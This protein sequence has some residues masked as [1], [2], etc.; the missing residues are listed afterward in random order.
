MKR[1]KDIST[2]PKPVTNKLDHLID[3]VVRIHGGLKDGEP[4]FLGTGMVIAPNWVLTCNHVAMEA[5]PHTGE[6][7]ELPHECFFIQIDVTGKLI[8]ARLHAH[9]RSSDLALLELGD[10]IAVNY[11]TFLWRISGDFTPNICEQHYSVEGFQKKNHG[12]TLEEWRNLTV[13]IP[14]RNKRENYLSEL[15]LAGSTEVGS[16]GSPLILKLGSHTLC[17]GM[18]YLGG[19]KS[20]SSKAASGDIIVRFLNSNH[21]KGVRKIAAE[22]IFIASHTQPAVTPN[23]SA[24]TRYLLISIIGFIFLGFGIWGIWSQ[25]G[26]VSHTNLTAHS[27]PVPQCDSEFQQIANTTDHQGFRIL[28]LSFAGSDIDAMIEGKK[29][30]Q[31]LQ[32]DI[33]T[34]KRSQ[35]EQPIWKTAHLTAEGL[36]TQFLPCTVASHEDARKVGIA[37]QFDLAIWGQVT[38]QIVG[39]H[40]EFSIYPFATATSFNALSR[41]PEKPQKIQQDAQFQL[42]IEHFSTIDI[43]LALYAHEQEQQKVAAFHFKKAY[44]YISSTKD[45]WQ[46]LLIAA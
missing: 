3:Y 9:D 40:R 34:Y 22:D 27:Q 20:D 19:G 4:I 17:I 28:V 23:S 12:Q 26:I 11:P 29:I 5:N 7:S 21:I 2:S 43:M 16:S 18:M 42:P 36:N 44:R 1:R 13:L 41:T 35:E 45:A 24:L 14:Q 32:L 33:E 10:S 39:S 25:K 31:Q 37:Q 46:L 6:P 8:P 15:L 38:T 30:A